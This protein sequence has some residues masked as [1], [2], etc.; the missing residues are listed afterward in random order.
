MF[1]TIVF[2]VGSSCAVYSFAIA[3]WCLSIAYSLMALILTLF[4]GRKPVQWIIRRYT[5][6]MVQAMR[7]FAGI[8][9]DV[10]GREH[11]PDQPVI[12]ACKHHS[13]GDGFCIY[14]QFDD[15]A[16]VTGDH[17]EKFPLMSTLLAKLG[18][19]GVNNCGGIEACKA[20][21]N[22]S[23][24]AA[25]D[26]RNILIYPEGHPGISHPHSTRHGQGRVSGNLKSLHRTTYPGT[27]QRSDRYSFYAF[28]SRK[29]LGI[30]GKAVIAWPN[31]KKEVTR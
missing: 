11:I 12:F 3:Y 31:E 7:I 10:R 2:L 25:R 15:L 19:I 23:A 24:E 5:R 21:A 18:A 26:G 16:F 29:R 4:P 13:W 20:L 1:K 8:R 28:R 17:L 9:L 6:R 30:N 22:H 14:S 27:D